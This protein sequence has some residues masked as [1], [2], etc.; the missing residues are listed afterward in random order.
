MLKFIT[1]QYDSQMSL[2][3]ESQ[4]DLSNRRK[5]LKIVYFQRFCFLPPTPNRRNIW[6][7]RIFPVGGREYQEYSVI[8]AK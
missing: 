1:I 6:G 5:P 3:G 8:F 7:Q 4:K 2:P